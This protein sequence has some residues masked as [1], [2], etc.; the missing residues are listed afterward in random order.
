MRLLETECFLLWGWFLQG[1][2]EQR[3]EDAAAGDE[4]LHQQLT[5]HSTAC[6]PSGKALPRSHCLSCLPA[7]LIHGLDL[8]LVAPQP[9]GPHHNLG[10][11]GWIPHPRL[12]TALRHALTVANAVLVDSLHLA[13]QMVQ[14]FSLSPSP[15]GPAVVLPPVCGGQTSITLWPGGKRGSCPLLPTAHHLLA[16]HPGVPQT[17]H[18]MA[19]VGGAGHL[20]AGWALGDSPVLCHSSQKHPSSAQQPMATGHAAARQGHGRGK[21]QGPVCCCC[22]SLA[23]KNKILSSV[24]LQVFPGA[25]AFSRRVPRAG[26]TSANT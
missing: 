21:E 7:M 3:A 6:Q 5:A 18:G 17:Q 14:S 15:G 4:E 20:W 25:A 13:Q 24:F 26:L 8:F 16:P 2:G 10:G 23:L 11:P 1:S 9:P 22:T 19:A 12:P